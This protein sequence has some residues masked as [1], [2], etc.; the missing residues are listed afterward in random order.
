MHH[1]RLGFPC[2]FRSAW[3][4]L[5]ARGMLK[6]PTIIVLFLIYSFMAVSSCLIYWDVPLF[7]CTYLYNCY[8]YFLDWSS[9]YYVISF[10][11][12]CNGHYFNVYVVWYEY[13][14]PSFNFLLKYCWLG[15]SHCVQLYWTWLLTIRMWVWSLA[16][17]CGL[18]I[19]C[20]PKLWCRLQIQ[21]R[22]C[23]AVAVA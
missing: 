13:C 14:Y 11:I 9:D 16:S 17:L 20:C 23:I 5:A 22:S 4:I 1:P 12:S 15:N 3:S 8:I 18:S 7:G 6:S 21:L 2:D 19:W 10:C